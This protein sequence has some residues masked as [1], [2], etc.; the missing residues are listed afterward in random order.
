MAFYSISMY[1]YNKNILENAEVI[2][3]YGNSKILDIDGKSSC[4]LLCILGVSSTF[5]IL[6]N[7]QHPDPFSDT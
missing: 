5:W 1:L 7:S 3:T 6:S 2:V 4:I